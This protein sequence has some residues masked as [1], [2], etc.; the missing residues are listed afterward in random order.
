MPTVN[1]TINDQPVSAQLGER[2]LDVARREQAHIG[3]ACDGNGFCQTCQCRVLAGAEAL[4]PPNEVEQNW[5]PQQ[6]LEDG[7]RLACQASVRGRGPVTTITVAEE[8]RRL[9][10]AALNS[11]GP[12]RRDAQRDLLTY[13][14][15]MSVDQL[16]FYPWNMMSA[17]LRLINSPPDLSSERFNALLRDAQAVTERTWQQ[18][19]STPPPPPIART[20]AAGSA[21][22][23][24]QALRAAQRANRAAHG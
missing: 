22:A 7:Y 2:L 19:G 4:S 6:R 14:T 3:F 13:L 9:T 11:D 16:V 23:V 1:V 8:L 21:E 24:T 17:V 20:A 10:A 15:R 5:L 12:A 18:R